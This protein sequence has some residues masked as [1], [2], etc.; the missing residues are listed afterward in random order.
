MA[1]RFNI[2]NAPPP[3]K[4]E[5]QAVNAGAYA[6]ETRVVERVGKNRL[7]KIALGGGV[8]AAGGTALYET[9][10]A[11]HRAVDSHF[12]DHLK[13]KSLSSSETQTTN[14]KQEV[15]DN[16]A[17]VQIITPNMI[18][19]IPEEEIQ[20]L[21]TF[22]RLANQ[23]TTIISLAQPAP[24]R[25]MAERV[26][27]LQN[28]SFKVGED[29][30]TILFLHPLDFSLSSDPN[31]EVKLTKSYGA[32]SQTDRDA[33][34]DQGYYDTDEYRGKGGKPIPKGTI[35][36][37]PVVSENGGYLLMNEGDGYVQFEAKDGTSYSLLIFGMKR[38][39]SI[40]FKPLVDAPEM[41]VELA[42]KYNNKGI[43][44]IGFFVRSNQAILQ[45]TKDIDSISFK[46]VSATKDGAYVPTNIASFVSPDNLL[47]AS[48]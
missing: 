35:A 42:Q 12:L 21:D 9:I 41:T 13:G 44:S 46:I 27:T 26:G 30:N 20:K 10:P 28:I 22:A 38:D 17:E 11:V 39:K 32:F 36:S 7:L 25:E 18:K 4:E 34:K 43:R 24:S 48:D 33:F 14:S 23:K 19:R 40:P 45:T 2:T 31:L 15:F 29:K 47:I 37:F 8:V 16:N 1:E 5:T 6:G 3:T